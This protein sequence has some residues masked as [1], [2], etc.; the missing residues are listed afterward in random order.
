[1]ER[2]G[3]SVPG[4]TLEYFVIAGPT[5]AEVLDRYTALTTKRL[6][7]TIEVAD[8]DAAFAGLVP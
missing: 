2:V 3:F 5:P 6:C 8:Q 7:Q 4:E 1:V